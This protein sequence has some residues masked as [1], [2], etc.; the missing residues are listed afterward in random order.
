MKDLMK[1][2]TA[3][4]P[5][6]CAYAGHILWGFSYLFTK[7]ALQTT[8]PNVLL[9]YRFILATVLMSILILSGK[10]HVSFKGKDWLSA[11]LLIVL[12]LLYYNFESYS[13]YYTNATISGAVLAVAPVAAILFAILLLK[14]FPSKR[15]AIFCILP[16]VGVILMTV[17][18]NSLGIV[19]AKGAVFL[20]LACITSGAYKTINRKTARSF[21]SFERTFLVL[22][23]SAVGFTISALGDVG[24]D[25]NTYLKPLSEP[26]FIL[27]VAALGI[28]CS[29]GANLLVNYA[30]GKMSVVKLSSFGAITTLCSMVSGV[31]LLGEPVSWSLVIGATLI[32][33]GIY[34][35]TKE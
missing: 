12:Q 22:S 8:G 30:V 34:Q 14:E 2:N 28:F 26:S 20:F 13:I 1:R 11:A 18:G 16:V 31:I 7:T 33:I 6:C 27:S 24:G 10:V 4:F 32:L 21:T 5:L 25:I 19:S 15:Q 3:W 35:V 29:I 17:A 9:S 23:A